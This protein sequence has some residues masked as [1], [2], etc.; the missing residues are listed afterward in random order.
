MMLRNIYMQG[1]CDVAARFI[2]T[3]MKAHKALLLALP[4]G[5]LR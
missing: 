3:L 4:V 2:T 1:M 5:F